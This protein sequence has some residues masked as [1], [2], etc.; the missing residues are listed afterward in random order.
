M[1]DDYYT[2][3]EAARRL[4]RSE[5]TITLWLNANQDCSDYGI[6]GHKVGRGW[7]I[8][9]AVVEQVLTGKLTVNCSKRNGELAAIPVRGIRTG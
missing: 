2:T 4:R 9:K 3:K 8:S 7:L 1:H 5:R 6:P